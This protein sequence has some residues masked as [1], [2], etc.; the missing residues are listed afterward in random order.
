MCW[1]DPQG[2]L[3]PGQW[4]QASLTLWAGGQRLQGKASPKWHL[5]AIAG[6]SGPKVTSAHLEILCS[7]W[8]RATELV[9]F[10]MPGSGPKIRAGQDCP[11]HGG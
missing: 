3:S 10:A 8:I 11:S 7:Q 5:L 4:V 2:S 9:A 6:T 1:A